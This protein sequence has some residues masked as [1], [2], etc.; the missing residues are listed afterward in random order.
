M[1]VKLKFNNCRIPG[2]IW[3]LY[4]PN[5]EDYCWIQ[6]ETNNIF[7]VCQLHFSRE[8]LGIPMQLAEERLLLHSSSSTL[9]VF[10]R[11]PRR[12]WPVSVGMASLNLNN[13]KFSV[14]D[15]AS[16]LE[17]Y[18]EEHW[19]V[20]YEGEGH[21]LLNAISGETF[22]AKEKTGKQN[23]PVISYE[24]GNPYYADV[25]KFLYTNLNL[26]ASGTIDY[27]ESADGLMIGFHTTAN[28]KLYNSYCAF[29]DLEGN[30]LLKDEGFTNLNGPADVLVSANEKWLVYLKN[31][32]ELVYV[33]WNQ[34]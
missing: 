8:A 9:L 21:I 14:F 32:E 18:D 26:Q 3:K 24:E 19:F 30:L 34:R 25:Q 12:D 20:N 6:Y 31:E 27:S 4:I 16:P 1:I 5:S 33:P 17:V 13:Q 15:K 23:D 29:W 2:K 28:Q 7:Y 11:F 10:K 22:E